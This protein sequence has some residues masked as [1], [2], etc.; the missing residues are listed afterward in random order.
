MPANHQSQR[1]ASAVG[2]MIITNIIRRIPCQKRQGA[3]ADM[4]QMKAAKI[5]PLVGLVRS[6]QPWVRCSRLTPPP[7]SRGQT[8]HAR[9]NMKKEAA[10]MKGWEQD[11]YLSPGIVRPVPEGRLLLCHPSRLCLHCFQ[12]CLQCSTDMMNAL[13]PHRRCL[14]SNPHSVG[15]S[16]SNEDNMR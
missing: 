3:S 14:E 11:S 1:E 15:H 16:V 10:A 12:C 9:A 8:D 2:S 4:L 5:L 6:K 7:A 13:L